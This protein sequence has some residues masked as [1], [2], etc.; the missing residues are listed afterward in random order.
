[1]SESEIPHVQAFWMLQLMSWVGDTT[2]SG[3]HLVLGHAELVVP[4]KQS[5]GGVSWVPV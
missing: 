1:M 3:L 5:S 4:L 2:G